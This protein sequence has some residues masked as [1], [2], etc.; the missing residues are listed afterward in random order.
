MKHNRVIKCTAVICLVVLLLTCI[1]V[2]ATNG[3]KTAELFYRNIKITLNGQTLTPKDANGN[4]V[5][6][7]I[8]DGTTYL[9]LRA[10]SAAL[11]L[12]VDWDASTSTVKLSEKGYS[13]SSSY[14]RLN[15][16]PIGTA[17]TFSYSS[18]LE[19]YT[20]T[21]V[22]K[23]C[24]RGDRAWEKIEAANMYNDEP[25]EGME[26]ILAE[27]S[28]TLVSSK[29]DTAIS[30]SS[31]SFDVYS[32]DSAEYESCFVVTPEPV[33]S[34]KV[35]PGGTLTGYVVF[36]VNKTDQHPKAVIGTDFYGAGGAWFALD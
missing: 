12:N 18:Y 4:V 27:V 29:D 10:I 1:T 28:L 25:N 7:F 30:F 6:P 3:S 21:C 14:S 19:D 23:S 22:I 2:Y 5:E 17:Q 16:A 15:P 26:Y 20:A 36:Q 11:G 35:F 32:S 33:F 9:P 8:I 24:I 31:Y 13:E 34:G